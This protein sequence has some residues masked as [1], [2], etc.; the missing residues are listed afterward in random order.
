MSFTRSN[1]RLDT[2]HHGPQHPFEDAGVVA[3][4]LTDIDN[5]VVKWSFVVSRSCI[6]KCVY[7]SL[8][9]KIQRIEVRLAWRPR[10]GS[11]S[12]YPLVMLDVT[13]N[14]LHS[15]AKLRRSTMMHVS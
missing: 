3:D 7:V 9:V 4:S 8:Q 13:E 2:S 1:A 10:S 11:S 14:I 12:T 15:T 6:F 5:A